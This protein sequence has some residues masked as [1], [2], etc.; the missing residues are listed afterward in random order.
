MEKI[1]RSVE[2]VGENRKAQFVYRSDVVKCVAIVRRFGLELVNEISE[3]FM[4]SIIDFT[5]FNFWKRS[6][7]VKSTHSTKYVIG[8]LNYYRY[9]IVNLKIRTNKM[10]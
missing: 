5:S 8:F 6:H 3:V 1:K 4:A 7:Y 9:S 10:K 2:D